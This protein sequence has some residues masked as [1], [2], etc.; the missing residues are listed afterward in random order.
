MFEINYVL[1]VYICR[2]REK[3]VKQATVKY[4]T[5]DKALEHVHEYNPWW[6]TRPIWEEMVAIWKSDGWKKTSETAGKNRRVGA[7][8]GE[9][10]LPTYVGGAKSMVRWQAKMVS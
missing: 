3:A 1:T 6:V 2:E 9:R 10:A 4:L 5:R 7:A 8:E